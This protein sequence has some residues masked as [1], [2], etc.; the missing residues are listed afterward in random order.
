MT[1]E[2]EREEP[3]LHDSED[4]VL[5]NTL[6]FIWMQLGSQMQRLGTRS[7]LLQSPSS[8]LPEVFTLM[9]RERGGVVPF[10]GAKMHYC[11]ERRKA[12]GGKDPSSV[13]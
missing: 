13:V 6:N 9:K 4:Q 11:N 5:A 3:H 12:Y 1:A 2:E 10:F 8:A 7:D